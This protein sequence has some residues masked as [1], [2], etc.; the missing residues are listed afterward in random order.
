MYQSSVDS[1]LLI[2]KYLTI[3]KIDNPDSERTKLAQKYLTK[4]IHDI[5]KAKNKSTTLKSI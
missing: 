1:I 4:K 5:L 2:N 3:C